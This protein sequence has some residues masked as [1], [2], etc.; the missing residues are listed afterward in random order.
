MKKQYHYFAAIISA[1]VVGLGQVVK[2]ESKKGLLMML[3]FYLF[4]PSIF[5][6]ALSVNGY[7]A[8]VILTFAVIAG[9]ILWGYNVGDAFIKR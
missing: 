2:G 7:L 1:L 6:A 3:V 9:V 8:L 5:F 4:L